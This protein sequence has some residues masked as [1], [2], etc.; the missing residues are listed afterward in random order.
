ME[1]CQNGLITV[2]QLGSVIY[3]NTTCLS[4][5]REIDNKQV[6]ISTDELRICDV[7]NRNRAYRQ[8]VII[9]FIIGQP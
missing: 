1:G 7:R 5:I 4:H 3:W 6:G 8:N 2:S 9:S